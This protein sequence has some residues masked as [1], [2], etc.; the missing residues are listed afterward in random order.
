VQVS[1]R[2]ALAATVEA[3]EVGRKWPK[4]NTEDL[5]R[6]LL[7]PVLPA[8]QREQLEQREAA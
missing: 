4:A 1:Y 3:I 7:K 8:R 2:K 6:T 5:A